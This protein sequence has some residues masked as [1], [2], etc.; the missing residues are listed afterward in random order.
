MKFYFSKKN[1][2]LLMENICNLISGK[3]EDVNENKAAPYLMPYKNEDDDKK[4]LDYED[5]ELQNLFKKKGQ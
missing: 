3:I 5:E 2:H 1:L 4:D